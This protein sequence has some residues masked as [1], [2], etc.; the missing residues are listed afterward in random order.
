[1]T[2][3][4]FL[5]YRDRPHG[6]IPASHDGQLLTFASLDEAREGAGPLGVGAAT[7]WAAAVEL[8]KRH[9]LAVPERHEN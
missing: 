5:A 2:N 6:M 3:I 8:C 4:V 9:G 7:S 1:M